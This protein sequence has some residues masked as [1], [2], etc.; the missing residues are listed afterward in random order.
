MH[1]GEHALRTMKPVGKRRQ[2]E[3][4]TAK[5]RKFQQGMKS[6]RHAHLFK[7]SI[8]AVD[9]MLAKRASLKSWR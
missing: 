4:S 2:R 1:F 5:W 6:H 7:G 3:I 8:G 9:D